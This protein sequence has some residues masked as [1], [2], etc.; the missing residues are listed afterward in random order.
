MYDIIF[1]NKA[2]NQ[3]KKLPIDTQNR[4]LQALE[5]IRIR[6]H[7]FVKR[8]QGTPYFIFR[9]GFY[10]LILNIQNNKLVIFVVELGLRKN[11]YKK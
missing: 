1:Y 6:P 8:K 2:E 11:I 10:R 9:V 4:I 3:L 5:R 7:H